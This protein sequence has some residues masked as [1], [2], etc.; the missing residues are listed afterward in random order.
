MQ[1]KHNVKI[2][3][4]LSTLKLTKIRNQRKTKLEFRFTKLN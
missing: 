3:L 1:D 2:I 4:K